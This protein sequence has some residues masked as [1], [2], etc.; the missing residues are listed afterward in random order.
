MFFF[1]SLYISIQLAKPNRTRQFYFLVRLLHLDGTVTS[2]FCF[3]SSAD[4]FSRRRE[5]PCF[6]RESQDSFIFAKH[7][8]RLS[9]ISYLETCLHKHARVR[10]QLEPDRNNQSDVKR[11]IQLQM[12]RVHWIVRSPGIGKWFGN[13]NNANC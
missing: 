12:H 13:A 10:H 6:K 7:K 4:H 3:F 5:I 8:Q 1:D 11:E 2:W 9:S